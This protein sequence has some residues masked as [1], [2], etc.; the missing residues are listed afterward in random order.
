MRYATAT[1]FRAAPE[2]R[3]KMQ[4]RDSGISLVRLRKVV[5]FERLRARLRVAAPE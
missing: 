5:V 4:A 2:T 1:A 3:L